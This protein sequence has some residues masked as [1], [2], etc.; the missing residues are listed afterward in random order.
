MQQGI[1][2]QLYRRGQGGVIV[3]ASAFFKNAINTERGTVHDMAANHTLSKGKF[4]VGGGANR[5]II[6]AEGHNTM[7]QE[8][9]KDGNHNDCRLSQIT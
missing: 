9:E 1:G 6:Q 5:N 2:F 3:K 4:C 8:A 7:H